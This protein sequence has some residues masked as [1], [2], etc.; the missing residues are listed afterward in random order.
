MADQKFTIC[1]KVIQQR[2]LVT[3]QPLSGV[4]LKRFVTGF[5]ES[6]NR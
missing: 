4:D 2:A 3:K 6:V 5:V 1:L